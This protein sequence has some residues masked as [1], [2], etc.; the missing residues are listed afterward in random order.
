MADPVNISVALND[1]KSIVECLK[2]HQQVSADQSTAVLV[3]SLDATYQAN[4]NPSAPPQGDLDALAQSQQ[5]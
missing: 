5:T 1:L 3:A 4:I 2:F